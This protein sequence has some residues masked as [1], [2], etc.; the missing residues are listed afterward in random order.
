MHLMTCSAGA[1]GASNPSVSHVSCQKGDAMPETVM[2]YCPWCDFSDGRL[3]A[4]HEH[5][6]EEHPFLAGVMPPPDPRYT[7]TP[8]DD[9]TT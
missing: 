6:A 5:M 2:K 1:R 9:P 3:S 7:I 8:P 4:V